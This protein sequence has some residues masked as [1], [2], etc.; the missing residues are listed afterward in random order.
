MTSRGYSQPMT[1][2]SRGARSR[3]GVR[4]PGWLLLTAL[5]VLAIGASSALVFTDRV[6]LLKLAVILALWAAVVAAFGSV[7]YRRQSDVD[8]AKARDMKL[9]YDLQLDREIAARREYELTVEQ[10]LRRELASEMRNQA[11]D[12]VAALRAELA[13]L[14][15][16]L[17][18][19]FDTE[20]AHR[21]AIE[22]ERTTVRAYSDWEREAPTDPQS[23]RFSAV[24]ERVEPAAETAIIDVPEEPPVPDYAPIFE[25]PAAAPSFASRA[26]DMTY[27]VPSDEPFEPP[28]SEPAPEPRGRRHRLPE[29]ST[30]DWSPPEPT[31][32]PQPEPEFRS[33]RN[34]TAA[35]APEPPTVAAPPPRPE[36]APVVPPPPAAPPP[37]E[38]APRIHVEPEP[39]P[40]PAPEP[41]PVGRTEPEPR[42]A[43]EST[44]WQPITDN[45]QWLPPGTPGSN[46]VSATNGH[47][48]PEPAAPEPKRGRHS[49]QSEPEPP[50]RRGRHGAPDDD[51]IPPPS[52]TPPPMP[53]APAPPPPPAPQPAP[54]SRHGAPASPPPLADSAH[55]EGQSV[56][57]L[58][59]RLKA[60]A[61][62]R[63]SEGVADA[64]SSRDREPS[65]GGRRRR[66]DD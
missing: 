57:D 29:Y 45:G 49:N 11:A 43:A 26:N 41:A 23:R 60:G 66:R 50:R 9:V 8:Q 55:S 42:P 59:A 32:P 17:E 7:I 10:E 20:L 13:S 62:A 6:E 44:E 63:S 31:P 64:R 15:T 2:L 16:N 18:I 61:D 58:L 14:R 51:V 54:A 19:L 33:R 22:N 38:P 39:P 40:A 3:R 35:P 47:T 28:R 56:A 25:A 46:W 65:G 34:R 4:R 1:V 24:R 5:L 21:P 30:A 27:D 36:P 48:T 37:P 12:E 53:P 52:F